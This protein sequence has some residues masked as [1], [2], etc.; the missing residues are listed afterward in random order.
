PT[1]LTF[2]V[3]LGPGQSPCLLAHANTVSMPN[4][5]D[6][7]FQHYVGDPLHQDGL[8]WQYEAWRFEH[9]YTRVRPWNGSEALGRVPTT[10]IPSPGFVYPWFPPASA[11][12]SLNP[13]LAG[14]RTTQN[15]TAVM[16]VGRCTASGL[17]RLGV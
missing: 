13:Q 2:I 4:A 10:D 12:P 6:L 1:F 15:L 7:F 5:G 14:G 16:C 9:G 17:A 8:L 3:T 11:G